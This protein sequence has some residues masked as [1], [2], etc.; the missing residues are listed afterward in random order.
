MDTRQSRAFCSGDSGTRP[1]GGE[2][3][4]LSSRE[5]TF[6]QEK[7]FDVPFVLSCIQP[8]ACYNAAAAAW[9]RSGNDVLFETH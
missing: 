8:V 3:K 9:G 1:T 5:T 4:R 7:P 2:R 6:R